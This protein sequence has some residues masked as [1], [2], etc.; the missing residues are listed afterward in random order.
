MVQAC[1]TPRQDKAAAAQMDLEKAIAG[2]R[3]EQRQELGK[4]GDA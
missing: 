2:D 1:V 3:G 4:D